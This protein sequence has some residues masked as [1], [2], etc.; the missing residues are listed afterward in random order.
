MCTPVFL[1]CRTNCSIIEFD[2]RFPWI[3]K[4]PIRI[5]FLLV[6][7][8]F[9]RGFFIYLSWSRLRLIVDKKRNWSLSISFHFFSDSHFQFLLSKF[10]TIVSNC[11]ADD[12]ISRGPWFFLSTYRFLSVLSLKSCLGKHTRSKLSNLIIF[13]Y[14]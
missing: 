10:L 1:E 7:V 5:Y 11:F 2:I 14:S 9:K 8:L 6:T 12:F 4:L 3:Y 13:I